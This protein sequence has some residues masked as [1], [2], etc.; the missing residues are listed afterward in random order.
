[1]S[2]KYNVLLI[3]ISIA[4]IGCG[5]GTPQPS[6]INCS[7]SGMEKVLPTFKTEAERQAFVDGCKAGEEK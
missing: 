7:P 1:M 4:L 3:G 2:S 5:G 6:A